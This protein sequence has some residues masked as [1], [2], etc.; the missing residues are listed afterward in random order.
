MCFTR[1]AFGFGSGERDRLAAPEKGYR[2]VMVAARRPAAFWFI[3]AFLALSVVLLL[4][5]QTMSVVDYEFAVGLGLQESPEQVGAH[6]V[7]VNRAFGAGDTIVYIPLMVAS[8]AGLWLRKRWA[9]LTT[10]AVAGISAYWT[11]T[12]GCMLSFL[13]GTPGYSYAPPLG[14][15]IFIGAYMVFGTWCLFYLVSR[16]QALLR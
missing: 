8:L 3:S 2:K 15:W 12:I 4:L 1:R 5:G 9:L 7:Q 14:I 16:G 13:P 10:A 11:A 6:G